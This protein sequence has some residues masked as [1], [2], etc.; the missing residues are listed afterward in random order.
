MKHKVLAAAAALVVAGTAF[1]SVAAPKKPD[2]VVKFSTS[3]GRVHLRNEGNK[4]A[5]KSIVTIVCKKVAGR[6]SCPE[7]NPKLV[8]KYLNPAYPN[9]VVVKFG[10][11]KAGKNTNHVLDIWPSLGFANGTYRFTL[12][13]DASNN[14]AESNE[15]NNTTIVFK[16][17]P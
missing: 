2:L 7:P 10:T 1:P 6:G 5:K 15:G 9:A 8:A 13:A 3:N 12:I 17:V 11:L 14:N 16:T 4:N